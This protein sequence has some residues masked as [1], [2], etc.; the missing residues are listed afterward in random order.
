MQFVGHINSVIV[1]HCLMEK[2]PNEVFSSKILR[3]RLRS[4]QNFLESVIGEEDKGA[5]RRGML[6]VDLDRLNTCLKALKGY[7]AS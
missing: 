6:E 2:L 4:E 5:E 1:E 3:M 7:N